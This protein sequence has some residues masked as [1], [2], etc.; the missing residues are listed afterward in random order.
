MKL[1]SHADADQ[2]ETLHLSAAGLF[3]HRRPSVAGCTAPTRVRYALVLGLAFPGTHG[4]L[5]P[6]SSSEI[7]KPRHS[8]PSLGSL[9]GYI[10]PRPRSSGLLRR[11]GAHRITRRS[12]DGAAALPPDL[13]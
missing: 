6:A 8:K 2:P 13:S 1:F 3:V 5:S 9:H 10:P 7:R 11:P 12:G 4:S